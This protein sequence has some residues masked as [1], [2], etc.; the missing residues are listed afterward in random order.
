MFWPRPRPR[1]RPLPRPRRQPQ[2]T[3]SPTPPRRQHAAYLGID[4]TADGLHVGHLPG[5]LALRACAELGNVRPIVLLGGATGLIGDPS[6]RSTERPLLTRRDVEANVRGLQRDVDRVFDTAPVKPM[7]VNN[8]DWIEPM[9]TLTFLRD[10]GKHFRV[11][12]M[13]SRESVKSRLAAPDAPNGD[14]S[15]GISVTEFLYQLLQAVDFLELYRRHGCVLQIGGSDQWGNILGGCE[16]VRRVERAEVFGITVPLLVTRQG[17]KLGK[18]AG[19]AVWLS[20]D[21]TSNFDFYQYFVRAQDDDLDFMLKAL[22]TLP[23]DAIEQVLREHAASPERRIGQH[24]LAGAVSELVRG[25]DAAE[26]ARSASRAMFPASFPARAT[27]AAPSAL[28][29]ARAAGVPVTRVP[30]MSVLEPDGDLASIVRLATHCKLV[31]SANE[32]RRLVASGGMY[33]DAERVS[34]EGPADPAVRDLVEGTL[35][36]QGA[37]VLRAGKKRLAIIQLV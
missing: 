9:G 20:P 22:T 26:Q 33:V 8:I 32:A 34:G 36:A 21:K 4:P 31:R 13:L 27:D 25:P 28:D 23:E 18:S 16:L 37:F 19:N 6:G 7:L 29:A 35:G 5:L 15:E 30:R 24:A 14:D 3:G 10:V 17:Q 11:Q 1:P 2:H 12:T